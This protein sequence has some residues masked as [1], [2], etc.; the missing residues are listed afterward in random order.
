MDLSRELFRPA[1]WGMMAES[2]TYAHLEYLR[3]RGQAER[4]ELE[5]QVGYRVEAAPAPMPESPTAH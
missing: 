4:L 1:V 2:E 3:L 5:G